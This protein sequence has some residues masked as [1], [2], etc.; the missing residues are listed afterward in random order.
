M[1]WSTL[2]P[3]IRETALAVCTQK[4]VDALKLFGAGYSNRRAAQYLGITSSTYRERVTRAMNKI[5]AAV[6][7]DIAKETFAA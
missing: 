4:E 6:G 2:P 3:E 5:A 7:P 1:T